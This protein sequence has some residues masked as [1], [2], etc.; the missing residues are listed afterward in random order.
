MATTL[1]QATIIPLPLQNSPTW[2]LHFYFN[3]SQ[4]HPLYSSQ[5]DLSKALISSCL[6]LSLYFML[7]RNPNCLQVTRTFVICS[8]LP[9]QADFIVTLLF[10]DL[11]QSVLAFQIFKHTK[12]F[13]TFSCSFPFIPLSELS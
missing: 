6:T 3:G 4:T 8:L 7:K 10:L 5:K 2:S 11:F 12:L 9:L 13:I 1:V